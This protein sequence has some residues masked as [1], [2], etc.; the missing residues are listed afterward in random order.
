MVEPY[1]ASLDPKAGNAEGSNP[2][3]HRHLFHCYVYQYHLWQFVKIL[4][5]LVR[6]PLPRTIHTYLTKVVQLGEV[7]RLEN[8]RKGYK[9]WLP[10]LPWRKLLAREG[11]DTSDEVD[12][13]NDEDPG[14]WFG[15]MSVTS[16]TDNWN[17]DV[18]QGMQREWSEDLGHAKRRDPDALPPRNAF[19]WVMN[20]LYR[21]C[22]EL[23]QGNTLFAIKS[24][25][26]TS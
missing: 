23:A 8:E 25:V 10:K 6:W 20:T 9:L 24:G 18:I 4:S 19:E 7:I 12:N 1:R 14:T 15:P 16:V 5:E 26:L 17:L 3:S 13:D 22:A 2:P 21:G 11:L